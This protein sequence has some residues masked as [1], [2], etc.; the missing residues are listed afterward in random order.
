VSAT[1]TNPVYDRYFADPFVLQVGDRYLAYGTGSVIE[2]RAFEVLSS[3]NLVEWTS[4]GGALEPLEDES[5]TDYWAPEVAERDGHF[6]LYYSAGRDRDHRIRVALSERPEGPFVDAGMTVAYDDIF[7]IDPHPFR[8]D[9]GD[10]YLY[11]ARD[12]LDGDKVGTALEVDRLDEA[13]ATHGDPRT[14]LRATADWQL[15]QAGRE[16]YGSRYDWYT[17]EGPFVSKRFERYHLLYSGGAWEQEGYGVSSAIADHPLG[18]FTEAPSNGPAVLR[19][20]TGGV[21]GPGHCS[22]VRSPGGEDFVVYG[23][24]DAAATARRLCIDRLRWEPEGPSVLGPTT[25]PQ[26]RPL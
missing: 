19:G 6:Y 15:F 24:W 8:D 16:I 10:W 25:S 17:L 14:V 20:G 12:F 11:Y 5:L 23:A 4:L 9:N 22:L 18:P 21:V 3:T 1:F 26:P 7:C 2:G 13:T